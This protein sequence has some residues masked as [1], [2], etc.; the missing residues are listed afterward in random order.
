M[1]VPDIGPGSITYLPVRAAGG[2]LFIGDAHACQGDGEL[3]GT[4]VEY[5]STTTIKVDLIKHWLIAWPRMENAESI[6]SIGSARPL[7]DA[8]RIAY[9]D[10]I[11]WLVADY[12]FDQW[13]AY[14]LLSQCG[15]VRLG[16]MVDPKYSVGAMINKTLLAK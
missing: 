11:Y 10:L 4:A 5:A 1:D 8:T 15:K 7:E 13:D 9:R 14:M 12:G 3:C 6:M 2:R 16:N